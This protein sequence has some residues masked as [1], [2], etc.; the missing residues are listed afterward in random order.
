[1]AAIS[2]QLYPKLHQF[3]L[4][5]DGERDLIPKL[6]IKRLDA[7]ADHIY[8]KIAFGKTVPICVICTHNSRRSHIGQLMLSAASAFYEIPRIESFSGG[9]EATAF[10]SNAVDGLRRAGFNIV[11][12]RVSEG[13]N[14]MVYATGIGKS[15]PKMLLFSKRYDHSQNPKAQFAAIMVCSEADEACPVVSGAEFRLS[16]PFDDPKDYDGTNAEVKAYDEAVRKIGREMFY[17]MFKARQMME[18]A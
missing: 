14:N 9:T 13:G 17:V 10:H 18:R 16:L 11:M 3:A 4:K 15:L 5:L 7:L 1:M 8:T 6:R 12:T 2:A